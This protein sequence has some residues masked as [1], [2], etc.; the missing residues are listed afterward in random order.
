MVFITAPQRLPANGPKVPN[1]AGN[2]LKPKTLAATGS[3][4]LN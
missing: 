2:D 1:P 4:S 3:K